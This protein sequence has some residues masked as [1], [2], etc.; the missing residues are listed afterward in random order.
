MIFEAKRGIGYSGDI[1]IDDVNI[2][3]EACTIPG[4]ESLHSFHIKNIRKIFS[5]DWVRT[6][7]KHYLELVWNYFPC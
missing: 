3:D 1:S 5:G 4:R 6:H 2:I 7:Y